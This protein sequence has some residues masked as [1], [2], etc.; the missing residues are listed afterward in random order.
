MS[1]GKF[2]DSFAGLVLFRL[3]SFK[4]LVCVLTQFGF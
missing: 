4:S 3:L 2:L 1:G